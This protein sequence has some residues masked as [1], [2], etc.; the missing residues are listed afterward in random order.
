MGGTETISIRIRGTLD[1]IT[2]RMEDTETITIR[3]RETLDSETI[4]VEDMETITIKIRGTSD[5]VDHQ[6]I[7]TTELLYITTGDPPIVLMINKHIQ[8][9]SKYPIRVMAT[10]LFKEIKYLKKTWK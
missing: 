8:M 5:T 3:I 2:P 7:I 1:S 6:G 10:S 9:T 4:R